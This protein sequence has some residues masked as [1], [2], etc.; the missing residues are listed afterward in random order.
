MEGGAP[1]GGGLTHYFRVS[2]EERSA[3]KF[4]SKIERQDFE[5]V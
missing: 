2:R 1:T 4:A 3:G 5:L